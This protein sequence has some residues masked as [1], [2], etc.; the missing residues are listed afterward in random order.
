MVIYKYIIIR[1]VKIQ[2]LSDSSR[3]SRRGSI[4]SAGSDNQVP[5]I[6]LPARVGNILIHIFSIKSIVSD[7]PI[8]RRKIVRRFVDAGDL[9]ETDSDDLRGAGGRRASGRAGGIEKYRL[10]SGFC[11]SREIRELE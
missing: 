3:S 8:S 4:V 9:A 5:S 2:R 10:G 1:P 7:E 11:R 6:P